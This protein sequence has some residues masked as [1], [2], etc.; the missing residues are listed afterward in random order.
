MMNNTLFRERIAEQ[1]AKLDE[2]R[3][4]WAQKRA[5][6]KEGFMKELDAEGANASSSTAFS[7]RTVHAPVITPTTT[8]GSTPVTKTP[9]S[10]GA[11]SSVTGSD[12]DAVLVE[13]HE[14]PGSPGILSK[15]QKKKG[16]K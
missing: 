1:Q 8:S 9:E 6:I 13:A 3:Q 15:K 14:Q 16:K 12:D 5:S 4:W 2:E 7:Q 10:S 11:P